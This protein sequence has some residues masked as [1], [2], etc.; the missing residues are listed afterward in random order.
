MTQRGSR[1]PAFPLSFLITAIYHVKYRW[2]P[3]KGGSSFEALVSTFD[4]RNVDQST[5][6]EASL[7]EVLMYELHES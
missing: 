1:L 7:P 5:P 4:W 2:Q 3:K 6:A